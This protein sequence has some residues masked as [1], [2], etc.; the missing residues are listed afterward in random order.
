MSFSK[1]QKEY[2]KKAVHRWNFKVGATRSGKTY[3]DYFLI[4]KRIFSC[5]GTGLIVLIGHTK[6]C[7]ERN[8]LEP[9]R[10]IYGDSLVGKLSSSGNVE[11]FGKKCFVFGADKANAVAKIQGTSIEYC[12]GDEVAT[13]SEEV[14]NMLKSRLDKPNSI[15]DGTLN[16]DSP[17][18]WLKRFLDSDADIF[19][20]TYT[21][22]DNPYLTKEFVENL[23]KEYAGTAYYDRFILG[24]WAASGG[25][26]YPMFSYS[27]HV[28]TE[29]SGEEF[30][31][32]IDYG[33]LNPFSMGLWQYDRAK[34]KAYRIKE[35]Y[36]DGRKTQKQMTDE[37]YY[38]ELLRLAG[39]R[40]I[41]SVIIDPSAASFIATIRKHRKFQVR[42][43][44]NRVLIGIRLVCE[45]LSSNRLLFSPEC[46]N[47]FEEF[48]SYKW[49][50]TANE[51]RVIK[52]SDHAMDDI[53]YFASTV[54][55]R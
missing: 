48:A 11:L 12:Y 47:S 7:V 21:I 10:K 37:D 44:D 36:H 23:K 15:F 49:D 53:R 22:F 14:F 29:F 54:M 25:L 17:N 43:A 2:F 52:Q 46:K 13:W 24:R 45:L 41:R 55:K 26:V 27:A 6:G 32:S 39:D 28:C 4:P 34:E 50:E 40:K 20:Q 9:M 18:H 33:T 16:P 19:M 31:I 51:D 5:T 8:I 3:M 42:K 30:Y 35:F 1:L 38:N